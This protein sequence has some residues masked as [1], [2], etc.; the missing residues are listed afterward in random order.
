MAEPKITKYE[1]PRTLFLVGNHVGARPQKHRNV[2]GETSRSY[3][4][5]DYE[6]GPLY[7][8]AKKDFRIITEE[9]YNELSWAM[10]NRYRIS[11][12]VEDLFSPTK[13]RQIAE[14]VGDAEKGQS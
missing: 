4:S 11:K 2:I 1:T 14:I 3:I 10:A 12:A 5:R 8:L 6:H 9:E 13:L 7:R